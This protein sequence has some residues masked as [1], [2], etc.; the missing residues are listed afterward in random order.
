M[1]KP[2]SSNS[3]KATEK[4]T[5]EDWKKKWPIGY[6][7]I[8]PDYVPGTHPMERGEVT[9]HTVVLRGKKPER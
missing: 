6:R 5:R 2:K 9:L 8:A 3:R 4:I 1:P 7:Y